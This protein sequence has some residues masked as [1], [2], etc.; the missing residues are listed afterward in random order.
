M[1]YRNKT[2]VCFDG[3]NDIHYYR[4]MCAWKQND[5]FDFNFHNAHDLNFARDDSQEVSIKRQLRERLLNTKS[6]VVLIGS[7]TRYLYRFV[8][9]EMEQAIAM[10]LPIIAVNLNGSRT[11]QIETCPPVI[12]NE[13]VVYVSFNAKIIAHAMDNWPSERASL[14]RHGNSGPYY[15]SED[16]YRRLGIGV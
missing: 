12:R 8:K 13:L 7:G 6:L 1:P 10:D 2:Y 4:L 14:K 9:W 16:I 3:D 15:Y 11:Q 5:G